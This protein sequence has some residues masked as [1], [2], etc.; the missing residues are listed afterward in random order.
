MAEFDTGDRPLWQAPMPPGGWG[1]PWPQCRELA[2]TLPADQ[3]TLVGGLM[4]QLHAAVFGLDAVRPTS[5]VDMVLHVE[6]GAITSAKA[7]AALEGLGYELRK[8]LDDKAPAHRFVRGDEQVDVM[9][10]DHVAKKPL[11]TLGQREMFRVP[12]GT[13]ALRRTV[14]C[15]VSMGG[16][17]TAPVL[18]SIPN[19]LGALVLKGAA[20]VEDSRDASRH[21]DDAAVLAATMADPLAAVP[22]LKGSDRSRIISLHTALGAPDHPSWL[23]LDDAARMSGQD[24]LR[25]LSANPQDFAPV[26]GGLRRKPPTS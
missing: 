16:D 23:L 17:G 24:A 7:R 14:Y 11:P 6:T 3:W 20:F 25:I 21:L 4:V 8:S 13:Q 22:E 15:E 2:A 12:A 26:H 5:D 19:T 10:A 1:H 9:I 18:V